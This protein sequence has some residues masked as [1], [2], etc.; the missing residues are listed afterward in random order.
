FLEEE[1]YQRPSVGEMPQLLSLVDGHVLPRFYVPEP[2]FE[3]HRSDRVQSHRHHRHMPEFPGPDDEIAATEVLEDAVTRA[4]TDVAAIEKGGKIRVAPIAAAN[5]LARLHHLAGHHRMVVVV[6][7]GEQNTG[8]GRAGFEK[9]R[10][11]RTVQE[12]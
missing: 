3:H 2:F 7:C 1:N 6:G 5:I 10:I 9:P 11:C 12:F 4:V 8:H